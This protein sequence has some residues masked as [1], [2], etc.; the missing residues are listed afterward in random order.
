MTG[1]S[2]P[3]FWFREEGKPEILTAA[4]SSGFLVR[5]SLGLD[6][7]GQPRSRLPCWEWSNPAQQSCER[8]R[9]TTGRREDVLPSVTGLPAYRPC[10]R[11]SCTSSVIL[12]VLNSDCGKPY[13][14]YWGDSMIESV[15]WTPSNLAGKLQTMGLEGQHDDDRDQETY[16]EECVYPGC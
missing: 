6:H 10:C 11:E 5:H 12:V 3:S 13:A 9:V 7:L 8:N 1:V 4:I 2:R 14:S 16:S 15:P